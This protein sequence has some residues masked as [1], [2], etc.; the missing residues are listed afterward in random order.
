MRFEVIR[1]IWGAILIAMAHTPL[2]SPHGPPVERPPIIAPF[3]Q[4]APRT[5]FDEPV[6]Y[7]ARMSS[8]APSANHSV[9][10]D[11]GILAYCIPEG[12]LWLDEQ[13]GPIYNCWPDWCPQQRCDSEAPGRRCREGRWAET[14]CTWCPCARRA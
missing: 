14:V 5:L 13:P 7:S 11:I 8:V 6:Y 1:W 12:P 10:G 2:W 9:S 3:A 4:T